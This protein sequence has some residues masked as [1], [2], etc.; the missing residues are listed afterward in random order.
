M[1]K[2]TLLAHFGLRIKNLRNDRELSQE[3]LAYR[4][5]LDRTYISG[6]ERGIRNPSLTC[7]FSL[8]TGLNISVSELI[9]GIDI[10]DKY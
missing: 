10:D 3:A 7:I 5:E 8:S 1:K 9:K 6:L 2:E 4:C